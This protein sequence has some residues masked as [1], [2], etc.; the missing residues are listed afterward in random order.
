[1]RVWLFY[2]GSGAWSVLSWN[3]LGPIVAWLGWGTFQ[4]SQADISN[5]RPVRFFDLTLIPTCGIIPT[6]IQ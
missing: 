5:S 1:M 2:N 3:L 6:T 4:K